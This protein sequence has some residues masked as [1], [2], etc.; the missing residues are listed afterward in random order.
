[1]I[2]STKSIYPQVD[3]L[4][5]EKELI[6]QDINSKEVINTC[7]IQMGLVIYLHWSHNY[8][9]NGISNIIH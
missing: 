6:P 8:I 3:S 9:T 5:A 7:L 2:T 1:M 4:L